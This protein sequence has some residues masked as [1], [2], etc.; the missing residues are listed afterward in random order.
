M[1]LRNANPKML[2]RIAQADAYAM[3]CEFVDDHD[4]IAECLKFERY[5]RHPTHP[6][7]VQGMYTDDTQMSIAVAETLIK[8]GTNAGHAEFSDA[9]FGCFKRDPRAGYSKKFQTILNSATSPDH[10]RQMLS[11]TST[12]N[13]A[14]MRSVPLGIIDDP[15]KLIDVCSTQAATTHATWG[16]INSSISIALMSHFALYDRRDFS[17][18]HRWCCGWSQAH[19]YF[20]EPWRGRVCEDSI[21][22]RGLGMGMNTA[23][24]VQTLLTTETSLMAILRRCIEWGGDTDSVAAIAWGIA[25]SRYSNEIIPSFFD[26]DLE[27]MHKSPYDKTFLND[28]GERLMNIYS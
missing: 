26:D 6:D 12:N 11:T 7:F 3:A 28:L 19:N 18:M 1:R 17:S 10:M 13:G 14:A 16:G 20:R 8:H 25:S 21:D 2:L 9:F 15:K 5:M 24:A 22:G 4:H 23:W 27:N